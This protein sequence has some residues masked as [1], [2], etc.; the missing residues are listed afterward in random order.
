MSSVR[1]TKRRRGGGTDQMRHASGV[2]A[3]AFRW[4]F[5]IGRHEARQRGGPGSGRS[6]GAG[7]S[8]L[9]SVR[10][11]EQRGRK[12]A[13]IVPTAYSWSWT[14][15]PRR[16][17]YLYTWLSLVGGAADPPRVPRSCD[18]CWGAAPGRGAPSR[19]PPTCSPQAH[20]APAGDA[21]SAGSDL[22]WTALDCSGLLWRA[23][24]CTG[25]SGIL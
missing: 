9:P 22:V 15:A 4:G 1:G 13:V 23:L 25:C 24:I 12:R 7:A 8:P 19:R 18:A 11:L 5:Q 14:Q 16:H 6:P 3:E 2:L 10:C 20:T 17:E 21:M